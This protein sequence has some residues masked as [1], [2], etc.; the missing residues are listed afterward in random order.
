MNSQPVLHGIIPCIH[1]GKVRDTYALPGFPD[2]R[3]IY[4]TDRVSTHNVLHGSVVPDK[5]TILLAMTLF[6]EKLLKETKGTYTHTIATGRDIYRYLP[7]RR[8]LSGRPA[9]A[10][11]RGPDGP[12]VPVRVHL[13]GSDGG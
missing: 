11:N 5:G 10:S 8:G 7:P 4:V 1:Q 3:L 2:K 12:D 6:W 13:S 9:S